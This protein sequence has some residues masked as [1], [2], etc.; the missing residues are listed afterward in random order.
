MW[1][2][3]QSTNFDASKSNIFWQ[4]TNFCIPKSNIFWQSTNFCIQTRTSLFLLVHISQTVKLQIKS[5]Y[6]S[7]I[8]QKRPLIYVHED[9]RF[10]KKSYAN[11]INLHFVQLQKDQNKMY[12]LTTFPF[13]LRLC[14]KWE[15]VIFSSKSKISN[16]TQYF[17]T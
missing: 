17:N 9:F 16:H 1:Y 3:W 10:A 13:S 8:M 15:F 4:N 14:K 2:F 7:F 11:S 5:N 12:F 6:P